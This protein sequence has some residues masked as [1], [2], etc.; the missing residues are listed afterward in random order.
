MVAQVAGSAVFAVVLDASA[1]LALF[2]TSALC[3]V[4]FAMTFGLVSAAERQRRP[5]FS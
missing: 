4:M 5:A 1:G 2:L 3:L